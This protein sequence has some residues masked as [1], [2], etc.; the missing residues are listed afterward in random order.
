MPNRIHY[1]EV[2][3]TDEREREETVRHGFWRTI[4]RAARHISFIEDV[5]AGYYCAVDRSTPTRV[6]TTIFGARA[7]FV[8]PLDV[9]PDFITGIGF[10]DDI[11]VLL[12]TLTLVRAHIMPSH[13]EAARRALDPD[14][15]EAAQPNSRPN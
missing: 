15:N 3:G 5:V 9:I 12:G 7:Y 8:L 13:R 4:R 1:G 11:T 6:R 2:I 10:T 14:G